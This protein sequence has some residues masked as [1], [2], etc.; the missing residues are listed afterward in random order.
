MMNDLI[1]HVGNFNFICLKLLGCSALIRST[2]NIFLTKFA[3]YSIFSSVI[4]LT[5]NLYLFSGGGLWPNRYWRGL[6]DL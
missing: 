6:F 3:F 2:S 1:F 4:Q 5:L